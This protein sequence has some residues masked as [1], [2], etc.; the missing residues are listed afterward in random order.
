M[1]VTQIMYFKTSAS[2]VGNPSQMTSQLANKAGKIEGLS[3]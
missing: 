2:Y 3:E 1:S